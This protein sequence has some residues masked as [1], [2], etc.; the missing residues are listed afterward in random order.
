MIICNKCG[1]EIIEKLPEPEAASANRPGKASVPKEVVPIRRETLIL[2]PYV[3]VPNGYKVKEVDLCGTCRAIL[4][5]ELNRVKF[6]FLQQ[7]P[8][9]E[10]EYA[11]QIAA[12]VRSIENNYSEVIICG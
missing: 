8:T 4:E 7:Q 9:Q 12:S 11:E 2:M 5:R 3:R 1:S 6:E 10:Q